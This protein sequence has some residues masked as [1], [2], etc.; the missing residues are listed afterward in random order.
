MAD[1]YYKL[2]DSLTSPPPN[3][4]EVTPNDGAD[5]AKDTRAINVAGSGTVKVTTTKGQTVTLYIAAGIA[6]PVR[7]S[8]IWSTDTTA[9]GIVAMW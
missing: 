5:L 2:S 3:C 1:D 4:A 8:R 7:V 9:T 6:F